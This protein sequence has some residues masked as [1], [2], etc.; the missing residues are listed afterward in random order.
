MHVIDGSSLLT[1]MKG[2]KIN[3]N[4]VI[5]YVFYIWLKMIK[6]EIKSCK[7]RWNERRH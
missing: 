2:S 4:K 7:N 1:E 3:F 6:K 5:F